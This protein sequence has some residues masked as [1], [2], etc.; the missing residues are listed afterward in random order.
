MIARYCL[1][2]IHRTT[3][4]WRKRRPGCRVVDRDDV[5]STAENAVK[6]CRGKLLEF[7]K[8]SGSP[9]SG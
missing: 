3:T 9:S 5:F 7:P 1:T 2:W 6:G 8:L 4:G